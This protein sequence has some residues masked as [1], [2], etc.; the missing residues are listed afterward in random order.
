MYRFI[1][2]NILLSA[3]RLIMYVLRGEVHSGFNERRSSSS[4]LTQRWWERPHPLDWSELLSIETFL[5]Y[6]WSALS[7]YIIHLYIFLSDTISL[8]I[9]LNFH[10]LYFKVISNVE[11]WFRALLRFLSRLLVCCPPHWDTLVP[12]GTGFFLCN[13]SRTVRFYK[14]RE[15]TL[16]LSMIKL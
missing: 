15:L 5:Y 13:H 7:R 14:I 1:T 10:G 3:G 12:R 6:S 8:R 4:E 16:Y 11:K 9:R 2:W